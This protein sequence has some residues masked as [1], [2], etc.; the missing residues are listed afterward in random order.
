MRF[1]AG[2][3]MMELGGSL[4]TSLKEN[5]LL[6]FRPDAPAVFRAKMKLGAKIALLK[7]CIVL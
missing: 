3:G 4:T 1:S 6:T 2:S 5:L 7:G